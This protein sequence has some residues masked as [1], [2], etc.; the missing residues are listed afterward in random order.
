[1]AF[2]TSLPSFATVVT[3]ETLA[4]MGTVGHA[5]LTNTQN[6]EIVALATKMGTGASTPTSGLA[7]MGTGVGTS[8]W[9]QVGLTTGVSGVL[10]VVNGGTGQSSQTGTGLPVAQESPIIITPTIGGFGN[11]NHTHANAAGGGT[12]GA[13]AVPN[14]ALNIQSLSNPYKFQAYLSATSNL[15]STSQIIVFEAEL[16]DTN[17]NYSTSTGRYIAPVAGFYYFQATGLVNTLADQNTAFISLF[18]NGSIVASGNAQASGT[19]DT[20]PR[21]S[22][23]LQLAANDYVEVFVQNSQGTRNWLG[24]E[25]TGTILASFFE[26]HLVSQT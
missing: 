11:A 25:G 9:G 5:S 8:T 15:T 7:L 10:P 16:Y 21:V 1:M 19:N 4:N 17:N 13:A 6:S 22:A 23:T 2:P 3:S 26:G 18:K 20:Y 24:Y 14:L 12:L